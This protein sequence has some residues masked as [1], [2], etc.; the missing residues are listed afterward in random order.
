MIGP[1]DP[2]FGSH[3]SGWRLEDEPLDP[4]MLAELDGEMLAAAII[5]ALP[6]DRQELWAEIERRRLDT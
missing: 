4:E 2:I 3:P 5:D 6:A 1:F